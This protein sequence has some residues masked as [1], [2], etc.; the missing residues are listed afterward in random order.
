MWKL[1]AL[2]AAVVVA[3]HGQSTPVVSCVSNTGVLPIN[4][5]IR[6]CDTPPCLLPQL[7][8]AVLDIVFR[9]PKTIS[10]MRTLATAYMSM[11]GITVPIP[12]DLEQNSVTC[13]FLTNTYC[14]VMNGEIIQYTL[15]MFIESFFPEG[16]AVAIEFRVVD[17]SDQSPVF[18][19]RT[20]LRI[21]APLG[22]V[23]GNST[24]VN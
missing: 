4:T 22:R 9:A 7:E 11:F 13:N 14:P 8:N 10:T 18:C 16:T 5:Y 20:D 1:I 23:A 3:V 6:G 21:V 2:F 24:T 12:Y 15:N 17:A 19:L